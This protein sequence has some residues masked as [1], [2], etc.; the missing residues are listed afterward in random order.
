MMSSPRGS[1]LNL[2]PL[3]I[4]DGWTVVFNKF[5]NID[6]ESVSK[7]DEDTWLFAFSEDILYI[8]SEA[9]RK[10]NKQLELQTLGIDLGWYPEGDPNGSFTLYAILNEDW[11]NPL[12]TF[13]S[14]CK[15]DIVRT[16]EKWLFV[17][18][19]PKHF[20]NEEIFRKNHRGSKP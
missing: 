1:Y 10:Q 5:E 20:I 17:E 9:S 18:F 13:S 6:P 3:R 4:P 8:R 11:E 2:Q 12:L 15:D 19:M 14:R 16:L 7:S